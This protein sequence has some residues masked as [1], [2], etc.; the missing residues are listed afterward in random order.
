MS[1]LFNLATDGIG[2]KLG[3]H[4]CFGNR[5]GRAR[6]Q[7]T[8]EPYF[9]GV[10]QSRAHQFVLEFCSR[11]MAELD[12]WKTY[13]EGRGLGAGGVDVKGLAQDTAQEVAKRLRRVL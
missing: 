8:Y 11:V 6:F 3:F 4:V 13:G 1:R 9:P 7:R 2:V 10:L 5:F 12:L